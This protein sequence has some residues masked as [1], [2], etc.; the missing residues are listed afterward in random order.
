MFLRRL[1]ISLVCTALAGC[2]IGGLIDRATVKRLSPGAL[3]EA[4]VPQACA[5]GRALSPV[6]L[7]L[8]H[9]EPARKQPRL[10]TSLT[11]IAA[12]MCSELEIWE[13]ELAS[14]RADYALKQGAPREV[15]ASLMKDLLYRERR[16]H[17]EA[18]RRDS[19][20]FQ[21]AVGAF[22]APTEQQDC[23]ARLKPREELLYLLGL[24]AGLLAV[25]HDVH[26]EHAV[27]VSSGIPLQVARGA[28][29]LDDA[30]WWGVPGALQ[31]AVWA[32]VPG[33]APAG[34]DPWA[35]LARAADAGEAQGVWLARA[36]QAQTALDAGKDDLHRAAIAAHA[37][38]RAKG[39]GRESA[40][41]LNDY[42]ARMVQHFADQIWT[43]DKGHR[44][45]PGE[46]GLPAAAAK[47]ELSPEDAAILESIAGTPAAA[48]PAP[49]SNAGS[50]TPPPK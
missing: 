19:A 24:T 48:G 39:P 44:A 10:A 5:L 26:A 6:V 29:C 32:S 1:A 14:L 40:T 28:G 46:L 25:I 23:P 37:T 36:L 7:A 18:A 31:A 16:H 27:G 17:A 8:G 9:G 43:R 35:Q 11:L 22:G 4:D 49:N 30:K 13:T 38:A 3:A 2:S 20:A 50:S 15:Q 47:T 41:L 21:A 42:A 45:P 34:T 12:G 33:S